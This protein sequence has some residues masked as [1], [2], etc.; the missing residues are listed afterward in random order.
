MDMDQIIITIVIVLMW[1]PTGIIDST[2]I[3]IIIIMIII[4]GITMAIII[5][6]GVMEIMEEIIVGVAKEIM[7]AVVDSVSHLRIS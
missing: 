6:A 5:I 2:D 3:M 4:M 7:V 1:D